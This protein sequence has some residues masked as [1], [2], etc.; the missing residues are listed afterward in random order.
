MADIKI[1]EVTTEDQRCELGEG[2]HWDVETQ[3]LFYVNILEDAAL[4][5]YDYKS[6][7]IFKA[8]VKEDKSPIGFLIPV[9][10][11]TDEFVVGAAR[12]ILLIK[13]DGKSSEASILKGEYILRDLFEFREIYFIH[14][15]FLHSSC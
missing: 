7:E 13:W 11:K 9:D 15:S 5:R 1:E 6:G 10:G 3:S 8:T 14:P 4:F 2:P 12:R